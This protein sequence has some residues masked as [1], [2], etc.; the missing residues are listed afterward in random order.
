MD[1]G[2][3]KQG[4]DNQWMIKLGKKGVICYL[5]REFYKLGWCTGSGGAISI[6]EDENTVWIN[7][8]GVMKELVEEHDIILMDLK[9]EIVKPSKTPGLRRSECTPNFLQAYGLREGVGSVIHTHS[10]NAVMVAKLFGT[11]FQC[12]DLQMIKGI[13]GHKNTEWCVVPII[14][15]SEYD[16][17][18]TENI[19]RAIMDYPR[20]QAVLVRNHGVFVWG[21]NWEKAKIQLE[22]YEY[23]FKV[24]LRMHK[25]NLDIPKL[26]SCDK[27]VKCWILDEE[28]SSE[29]IRKDQQHKLAKWVSEVRLKK[30][31]VTLE[32]LDAEKFA[33]LSKERGLVLKDEI[34]LASNIINYDEIRANLATERKLETDEIYYIAAGTGYFD[35]KNEDGKWMRIHVGKGELLTLWKDVVMRF[36]PDIMNSIT[37]K[38]FSSY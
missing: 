26:P 38:K 12:I 3:S 6:R 27:N 7:P 35:I 21:P 19:K 34:S 9:G 22:C 2:C 4:S 33:E 10:M 28:K 13:V 11:E 37:L 16:T 36:S 31:N 24:I 8:S 20:S 14:E 17:G 1:C 30:Y 18:L 23:I 15:N 5:F 32:I 25:Y 29:D